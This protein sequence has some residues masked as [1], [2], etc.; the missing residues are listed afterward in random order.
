[1]I[2]KNK[3]IAEMTYQELVAASFDLQA[4]LDN[5]EKKRE[6]PKF[7][8]MMENRPPPPINPYFQEIYD[9][10]DKELEKRNIAK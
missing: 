10:V 9:A 4:M 2:Y 8:K 7:K 6:N 1:M 3:S 5:V